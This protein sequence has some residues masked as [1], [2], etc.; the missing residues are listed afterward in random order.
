MAVI[1][2][3]VEI[4]AEVGKEVE[5]GTEV[6]TEVETGKECG[7][8][9][10]IGTEDGK[11]FETNG[12]EVDIGM[13][14][15]IGTENCTPLDEGK[16]CSTISQI[17]GITLTNIPSMV[18]HTIDGIDAAMNQSIDRIHQMLAVAL[19]GSIPP[20]AL[21]STVVGSS[22]ESISN[23]KFPNGL[24]PPEIIMM[25]HDTEPSDSHRTLHPSN[26]SP[27][28]VDISTSLLHKSITHALAD[29]RTNADTLH[30][31]HAQVFHHLHTSTERNLLDVNDYKRA[32]HDLLLMMR[33]PDDE[34]VM[35]EMEEER[36]RDI[37]AALR[38]EEER[39]S[40]IQAALRLELEG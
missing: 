13:I 14:G 3:K 22:N 2:M 25:L 4:G 30:Q 11:E 16:E 23:D 20:C 9:V 38:L 6:G 34:R 31:M 40:D 35:R 18:A 33:E 39:H 5:I 10:E 17:N 1:G 27:P 24:V 7:M 32:R 28:V 15:T 8:A 37:Q 36:N 12:T 26:V 21:P 29:P 19:D